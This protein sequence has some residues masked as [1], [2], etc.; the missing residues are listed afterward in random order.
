MNKV[1]S[2]IDVRT[3]EEFN[4]GHASGSINIP[5]NEVMNRLDEI[6]QLPQ[7][8]LLCCASGIRSEQV[9]AMLKSQ[10][11]NCENGGGWMDIAFS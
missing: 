6:K 11:I 7:P 2:V 3:V 9:T 5:M 4:G 8:I 1:G 10:N